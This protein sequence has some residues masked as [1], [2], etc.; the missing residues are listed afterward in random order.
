[1]SSPVYRNLFSMGTRLD[2][3]FTGI[4]DEQA[5]HVSTIIRLELGKLEDMISNYNEESQFSIL[6]RKAAKQAVI[7]DDYI[8]S[9]LNEL[10][11][12]SEKTE[13]YY[14]FTLGGF[15]PSGSTGQQQNHDARDII[16]LPEGKGYRH[17]KTDTN[18][19]TVSFTSEFIKIDSGGFGKGLALDVMKKILINREINSCFISFG[20][21]SVFA[22]GSHP[23][24]EKWK[25]GIRNMFNDDE[26]IFHFQLKD[27]FLSVSGITPENIKKYGAGHIINPFTGE[28]VNKYITSAV[29]GGNGL[30][31]EVISTALLIAPSDTRDLIMDNF[32]GYKAVVIEYNEFKQPDIVYL[33]NNE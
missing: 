18:E 12:L 2:I 9:L 20:E 21:S 13:G 24:G 28:A 8:L 27:E 11:E 29:A 17:V 15:K 19:K 33:K 23:Y 6:N 10:K 32:P 30:Q 4:D 31:T 5:D 22:H 3:I 7:V 26:S 1:M 25:T 14:D 16:I